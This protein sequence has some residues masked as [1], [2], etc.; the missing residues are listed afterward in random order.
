M[1]NFPR[2]FCELGSKIQKMEQNFGNLVQ[3]ANIHRREEFGPLV[4]AVQANFQDISSMRQEAGEFL[5]VLNQRVNQQNSRMEWLY[6]NLQKFGKKFEGCVR[7]IFEHENGFGS[8]PT[9]IGRKHQEGGFSTTGSS[10]KV[11]SSFWEIGGSSR[12]LGD[13]DKWV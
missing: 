7:A 9:P 3:M 5:D 2:N 6:T 11:G 4:Q 13:K 12:N 8:I 1:E 10:E